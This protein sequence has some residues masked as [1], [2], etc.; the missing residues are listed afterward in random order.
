MIDSSAKFIHNPIQKVPDPHPFSCENTRRASMPHPPTHVHI[1]YDE[2]HPPEII[3]ERQYRQQTGRC[4]LHG[5]RRTA[6]GL[7][8]SCFKN[9]VD[10][11]V[12]SLQSHHSDNHGSDHYAVK[13]VVAVQSNTDG[14]LMLDAQEYPTL[15]SAFAPAGIDG[16]LDLSATQP[17]I[18][19]ER[20]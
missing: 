3:R 2:T 4:S 14:D 9:V 15:D 11:M 5:R 20:L 18:A 16:T 13:A 17:Y 10:R 1:S 8:A 12:A 19:E 7:C 6:T